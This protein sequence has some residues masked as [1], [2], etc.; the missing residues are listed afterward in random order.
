MRVNSFANPDVLTLFDRALGDAPR[1]GPRHRGLILDLRET[2]GTVTGRD[3]GYALLSRLIDRP[4]LTARRRTPL[5]SLDSLTWLSAPSD[6]IWP[7]PRRERIAYM[8][9]VVVLSSPRT[10]GAAEDFLVAF[11]AGNRGPIIGEWS[12]GSTGKT[13]VLALVDGWQLRVT[14]TRDAFPDGKEFVRT[15]IAPQFPVDVRAQDVLVG[16]DAALDRARAYL[17][18]TARR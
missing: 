6:T 16:R 5:Y 18:E 10:S 17:T 11:E 8:G 3:Q 14:V 9:P 7:P 12:A 4:F 15:G 13:A 2:V 1:E